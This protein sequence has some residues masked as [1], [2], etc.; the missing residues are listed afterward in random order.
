MTVA[1]S[2][3]QVTRK[4][5]ERRSPVIFNPGRN[6][7]T[8]G[9]N[10]RRVY[11]FLDQYKAQGTQQNRET[12]ILPGLVSARGT[13]IFRGRPRIASVVEASVLHPKS[14]PTWRF[15][16]NPCNQ[17]KSVMSALA[18]L[19]LLKT[20]ALKSF[21]ANAPALQPGVSLQVQLLP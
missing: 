10:R 19:G 17:L 12:V 20:H 3:A 1:S 4:G 21:W 9:F 15:S 8:G 16:P 11:L 7:D 2:I 18:K 6:R 14:K 13:Q 5:W